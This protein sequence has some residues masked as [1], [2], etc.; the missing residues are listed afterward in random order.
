MNILKTLFQKLQDP[1]VIAAFKTIRDL[2]V[3]LELPRI[4][5]NLRKRRWK[6]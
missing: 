1:T 2:V 6:K 3:E 5:V 4:Y